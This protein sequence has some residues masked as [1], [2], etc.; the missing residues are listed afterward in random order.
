MQWVL[1][2]YLVV[3]T[4][5]KSNERASFNVESEKD[6]KIS[7]VLWHKCLGYIFRERIGR[8]EEEGIIHPLKNDFKNLCGMY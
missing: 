8:I 1:D 7:Y 6:I 2:L 4:L 5:R 3:C